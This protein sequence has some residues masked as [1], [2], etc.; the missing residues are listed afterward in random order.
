MTVKKWD[1]YYTRGLRRKKVTYGTELTVERI[2][3]VKF[4]AYVVSGGQ[5]HM[6]AEWL[7][8]KDKRG[9]IRSV[10]LDEVKRV[11]RRHKLGRV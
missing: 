10:R 6:F 1:E 4:I 5:P 3:R 7:D 9:M 11:H 8:V 2:G